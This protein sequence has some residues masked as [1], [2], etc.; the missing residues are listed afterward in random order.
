MVWPLQN[1]ARCHQ[2]RLTSLSKEVES[3]HRNQQDSSE[4][5]KLVMMGEGSNIRLVPSKE[6][7]SVKKLEGQGTL[8]RPLCR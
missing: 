2:M 5:F 7:D 1:Q 8:L 6:W 3:L 4:S